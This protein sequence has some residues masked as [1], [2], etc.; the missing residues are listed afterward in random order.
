M[1]DIS[2]KRGRYRALAVACIGLGLV[3]LS[4]YNVSAVYPLLQKDWA[5]GE[6][7]GGLMMACVHGGYVISVIA[8]GY[9]AGLIGEKKV[10]TVGSL[11][12]AIFGAAFI[13]F[14]RSW[15]VGAALRFGVGAGLGC[16][17]VPAM[18]LLSRIFPSGSSSPKRGDSVS[19]F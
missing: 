10:V 8:S 11:I 12:T 17:Y 1:N 2:Q 9:V 15:A 14:A 7:R 13:L 18:M 19:E 16:V 3:Y 6:G 4:E 5:L